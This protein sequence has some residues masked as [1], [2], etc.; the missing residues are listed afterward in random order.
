MAPELL[1]Q[2]PYDGRLADVWALGVILYAILV[3]SIPWTT[4]GPA[5]V[6]Q[7][8]RDG[9]FAS[10]T[11][12]SPLVRSLIIDMLTPD[13]TERIT[14]AGVI[15]HPWVRADGWTPSRGRAPGVVASASLRRAPIKKQILVRPRIIGSFPTI[16]PP[17]SLPPPNLGPII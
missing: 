15:A 10:A 4:R 9:L 8:V 11:F 7:Q 1:F 3:G 14:M 5:A 17:V 13:P 6:V 12:T 16:H 2:E